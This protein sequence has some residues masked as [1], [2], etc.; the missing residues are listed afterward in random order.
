LLQFMRGVWE[1]EM[2]PKANGHLMIWG[3]K[4]FIGFYG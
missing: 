1:L 2:Y 4:N 3:K